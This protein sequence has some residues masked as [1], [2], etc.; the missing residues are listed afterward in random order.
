MTFYLIVNVLVGLSGL[1]YSAAL[2]FSFDSCTSFQNAMTSTSAFTS[3]S[4]THEDLL[5]PVQQ[6]TSGENSFFL[7][8]SQTTVQRNN[9]QEL[10]TISSLY[11]Q[12][13]PLPVLNSYSFS[14]IEILKGYLLHLE[15]MPVKSQDFAISNV[16]S[17]LD[18]FT[19]GSN[20]AS[21]QISECGTSVLKDQYVF[22]SVDCSFPLIDYATEDQTIDPRCIQVPTYDGTSGT[23]DTN[24]NKVQ[25]TIVLNATCP[26][27]SDFFDGSNTNCFLGKRLQLLD[28][29][30]CTTVSASYAERIKNLVEFSK[31]T[32]S[33]T[34]VY[35]QN[36]RNYFGVYAVMN[37]NLS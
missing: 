15:T 19:N 10:Y 9:L 16:L 22:N 21:Q 34:D 4:L 6:C 17:T 33:Y 37:T 7:Q 25:H 32:G 14:Q 35:L 28:N 2:I 26:T 5:T 12:S 36:L 30:G 24:L 20:T 13:V 23:S 27:I 1:Y 8:T 11:N 3:L 29:A 18:T 31:E